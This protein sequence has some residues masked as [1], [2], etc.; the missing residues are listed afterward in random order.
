MRLQIEFEIN[1]PKQLLTFNYQYPLSSWIYGIISKGN[2]VFAEF[3]HEKGYKTDTGKQ[4]KLF[5]FSGLRFPGKTTKQSPNFPGY[6]EVN[7]RKAYLDVS[8]FL[9]EQLEP[10]VSGLFKQQAAFIGDKNHGLQMQVRNIEMI[11]EPIFEADK[12][13]FCKTKTA[14]VMGELKEDSK[15]EQYIPPLSP[16][17]NQLI[18]NNIIDK[19]RSV[20]ININNVKTEDIIFEVSKLKAKTTL[21]TIKANTDQETKVKGYNYEFKL[22]ASPEI[23]KL[24]YATGIGSMNSLGFGVWEIIEVKMD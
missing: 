24:I 2:E 7:S 10:F 1:K 19:C 4:F 13:Y 15:H 3:L 8:F 21:Q 23:L 20:G 6:L 11:K 14:V 5:T 22:K 18:I 16:N 17:Y 12:T 9:P